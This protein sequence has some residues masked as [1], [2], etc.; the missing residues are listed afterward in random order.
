MRRQTASAT[1]AD[2]LVSRL[3][4][5]H[6]APDKQGGNYEHGALKDDIWQSVAERSATGRLVA[7]PPPRV[8]R[9]WHLRCSWGY[10]LHWWC[11]ICHHG[12]EVVVDGPVKIPLTN[13]ASWLLGQVEIL[14]SK[15]VVR[16][17]CSSGEFTGSLGFEAH[18]WTMWCSRSSLCNR[19]A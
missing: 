5:R 8:M 1:M 14:Q 17:T 9:Q 18:T 3:S 12:D 2:K 11:Y 10:I 19:C 7:G 15:W 13:N 16:M 4:W 6:T